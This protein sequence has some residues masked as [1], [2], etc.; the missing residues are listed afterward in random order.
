MAFPFIK[1]VSFI[2]DQLTLYVHEKCLR[3]VLFIALKQGLGM[4]KG[5][6]K[7]GGLQLPASSSSQVHTSPAVRF[8]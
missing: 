5:T 8:C 3:I 1:R 2:N 4:T 6:D 7:H